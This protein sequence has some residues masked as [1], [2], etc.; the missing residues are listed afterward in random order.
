MEVEFFTLFIGECG[1]IDTDAL[2][3]KHKQRQE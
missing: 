1:H 3:N 2:Q